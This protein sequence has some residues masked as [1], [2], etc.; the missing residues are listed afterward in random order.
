MEGSSTTYFRPIEESLKEAIS[1]SFFTSAPAAA[2]LLANVMVLGS[3]SAG[4]VLRS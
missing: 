3:T 4:S 2:G 1:L